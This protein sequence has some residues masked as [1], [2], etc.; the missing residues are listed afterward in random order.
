MTSTLTDI[1]DTF[2]SVD[3]ATR[4]D[5]L[6]D[7]ARKLPPL[8]PAYEAQR[9][10]GVARVHECMTPVFLW[11]E[12]AADDTLDI[13]AH[14]A[15]EAPTIAGFMGLLRESLQGQPVQ[16]AM[17]LPLDLPY[18]LKLDGLLRMNRMVGLGAMIARLRAQAGK[19]DGKE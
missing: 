19:L 6:L 2:A 15:P 5:L 12:K 11:V 10:A 1:V 4:M 9:Q 18:L 3:D 8:P 13:H 16:A 17:D 7:F 14:I